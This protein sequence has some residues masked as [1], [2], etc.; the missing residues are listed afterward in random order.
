MAASLLAP[1]GMLA[2]ALLAEAL[3]IR[4]AMWTISIGVLLASAPLLLQRR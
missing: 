3:G 2:G 4:A 1:I